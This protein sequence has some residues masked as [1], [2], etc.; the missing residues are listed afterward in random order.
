ML[1]QILHLKLEQG[2]TRVGWDELNNLLQNAQA[3]QFSRDSFVQA[4]N[5]DTRVRNLVNNFDEAG[6]VLKGGEDPK[7]DDPEDPTVDQMADRATKAALK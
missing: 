7:L 3:E 4:F 5:D 2:A 6:V 1:A